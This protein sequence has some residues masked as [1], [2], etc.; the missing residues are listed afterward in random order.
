MLILNARGAETIC[1]NINEADSS[2]QILLSSCDILW[3]LLERGSKD[4]VAAQ[5]SS[6]ECV[7]YVLPVLLL[8]LKYSIE[9]QFY[10]ACSFR[11]S[12]DFSSLTLV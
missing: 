6:M 3:N 1:L 5:L 11:S 9:D 7:T 12:L 8:V 4:E 10:S 2:G